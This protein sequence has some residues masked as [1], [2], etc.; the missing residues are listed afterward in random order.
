MMMF[1]VPLKVRTPHGRCLA[2]Y[3]IPPGLPGEPWWVL[4]TDAQ[5]KWFTTMVEDGISG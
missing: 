3:G 5:G 1:A 2:R 4:Y